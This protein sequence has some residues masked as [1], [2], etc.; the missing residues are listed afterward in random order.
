MLPAI[1]HKA[2]DI[3]KR[4]VE[5]KEKKKGYGLPITS[6]KVRTKEQE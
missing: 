5:K 4:K 2:E 1:R 3:F 6:D